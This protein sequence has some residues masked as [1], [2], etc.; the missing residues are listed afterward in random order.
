MT[1]A[2][3]GGTARRD[4]NWV[5]AIAFDGLAESD[6]VESQL[7][8]IDNSDSPPPPPELFARYA[9]APD[10]DA[11]IRW[12]AGVAVGGTGGPGE[13]FGRTYELWFQPV[14]DSW[15]VIA[16][17]SYAYPNAPLGSGG[18]WW[19]MQLAIDL[20]GSV[21]FTINQAGSAGPGSGT[22]HALHGTSVLKPGTWYHL[23][24]QY[25]TGG[26]KLFVNG[27]LEASDPYGRA[28][29]P[30]AGSPTDGAFSLGALGDWGHTSKGFYE[31][32]FVERRE[33]YSMGAVFPVPTKPY[34][35]GTVCDILDHLDGLTGGLNDGFGSAPRAVR[36]TCRHAASWSSVG[37][38]LRRARRAPR[39]AAPS[40]AITSRNASP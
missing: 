25:G 40:A 22:E 12:P 27:K 21:Y 7:F 2:T 18:R 33:R 37:A 24:A 39:P 15:G 29:Q 9:E 34:A 3:T 31:E 16:S 23:A 26:M 38:G 17:T 8:A 13:P 20:F 6:P 10:L 30:D 11:V 36:R 19:A 32:V 4:F 1:A 28:P 5:R 35:D 14:V